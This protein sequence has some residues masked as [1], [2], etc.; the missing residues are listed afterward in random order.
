M[1]VY[2]RWDVSVL[3]GNLLF[4]RCLLG[5]SFPILFRENDSRNRGAIVWQPTSRDDGLAI[6]LR[7]E[8]DLLE[9][10]SKNQVINLN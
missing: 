8:S 2:R 7:D 4:Y 9:E 5:F 6:N 1:V 10:K 3:P